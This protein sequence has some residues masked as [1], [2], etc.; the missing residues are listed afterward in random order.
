MG[1]RGKGVCFSKSAG[2]APIAHPSSQ[3][4]EQM[5][6]EHAQLYAQDA[7][8]QPLADQPLLAHGHRRTWAAQPPISSA[9]YGLVGNEFARTMHRQRMYRRAPIDW[10]D[11][12]DLRDVLPGQT[13]TLSSHSLSLGSGRKR[14]RK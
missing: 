6:R 9:D 7:L 3:A 5:R 4:I 10:R 14:M 1:K 11:Y 2:V 12:A 8:T 13:R